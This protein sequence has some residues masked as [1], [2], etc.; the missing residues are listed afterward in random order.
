MSGNG[1]GDLIALLLDMVGFCFV[2]L[3]IER[4]C[5]TDI[6]FPAAVRVAP[7]RGRTKAAAAAAAAK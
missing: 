7:P 2:F 6:F 3:S 5:S 1:N 4:R